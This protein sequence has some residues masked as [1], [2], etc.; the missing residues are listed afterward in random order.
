LSF[1]ILARFSRQ[2]S[3][4]TAKSFGFRAWTNRSLHGFISKR[5]RRILETVVCGRS[6]SRLARRVDFCGLRWKQAQTRSTVASDT[7]GRPGLLPLQMR[8]FCSNFLYHA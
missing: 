1:S 5:F 3:Y 8:P 7:E 6:N 4:R 2:N